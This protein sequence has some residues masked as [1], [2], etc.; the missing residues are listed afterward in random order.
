MDY[1]DGNG[2]LN[3]SFDTVARQFLELSESERDNEEQTIP[4]S[5]ASLND[6]VLKTVT[7]CIDFVI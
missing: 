4:K 7:N 1:R 3:K 5:K 2:V 6:V